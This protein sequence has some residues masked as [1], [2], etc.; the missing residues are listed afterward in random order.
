VLHALG[1]REL[2]SPEE[3]PIDDGRDE[4]DGHLHLPIE[5]ALRERVGGEAADDDAAGEPDVERV[6][7]LG[8]AVG[9]DGRRQRVD[10]RLDEAVGQSDGERPG[11]QHPEAAREDGHRHADDVRQESERHQPA[12]AEH[13]HELTAEEDRE[14][15][16]PEGGADDPAHLLLAQAELVA[17]RVHDVAADGEG[18][19]GGDERDATCQEESAALAVGQRLVGTGLRSGQGSSPCF[20][21]AGVPTTSHAPGRSARRRTASRSVAS[22]FRAPA[23]PGVRGA[24]SL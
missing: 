10:R 6:E 5:L 15:E 18:H 11:E 13:V 22:A 14:R 23:T 20:E 24:C 8:L 2:L 21:V 7:L 4:N 1:R 17:E 3:Q 12:H 16:A 19:G 9:V